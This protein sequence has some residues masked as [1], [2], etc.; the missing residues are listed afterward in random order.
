VSLETESDL[1]VLGTKAMQ[2]FIRSDDGVR[3][4]CDM[5]NIIHDAVALAEDEKRILKTELQDVKDLCLIFDGST[6]TGDIFCVC[7]RYVNSSGNVVQRLIGFNMYATSFDA[8][9]LL[10][11]ITAV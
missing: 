10:Q 8:H 5:T 2:V 4:N 9:R 6:T 3:V 7:A 11:A 1:T